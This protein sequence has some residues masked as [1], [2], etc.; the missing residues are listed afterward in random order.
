MEIDPHQYECHVFKDFLTP[1]PHANMPILG[2]RCAL[3]ALHRTLS[4]DHYAQPMDANNQYPQY[5]PLVVALNTICAEFNIPAINEFQLH[6]MQ[7]MPWFNIF[8]KEFIKAHHAQRLIDINNFNVQGSITEDHMVLMTAAFAHVIG[9]DNVSLGIVT[10]VRG[11]PIKAFHYPETDRIPDYTAWIVA[12]FRADEPRFYGIGRQVNQEQQF[13]SEQGEDDEE[14]DEEE[15]DEE[16]A[17]NEDTPVPT[18][19]PRKTAAR[20]LQQQKPLAAGLT[21]NDILQHHKSHLQYNNILK[22]GLVYSNQRIAE[23]CK[24]DLLPKNEQLRHTS[25]VVKRINTGITWIEEQYKIDS[26]AFRTAYDRQ[27]RINGIPTRGKDEIGDDIINANRSKIDAAMD[28]IQV[29]GP[30]PAGS[31]GAASVN[32]A[33]PVLAGPS[34]SHTNIPPGY[35]Q[36]SS[37]PAGTMRPAAGSSHRRGFPMNINTSMMNMNDG[38]NGIQSGSIAMTHGSDDM[39]DEEMEMA[40]D[41]EWNPE[42]LDP[43]RE[44]AKHLFR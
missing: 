39:I 34:C 28:W 23:I 9:L 2:K 41:L 25:A 1:N 10:L 43:E 21:A 27:R 8:A 15:R 40:N 44:L 3:D 35:T 19:T 33:N 30:R 22:V 14:R 29:G 37:T 4:A 13:V 32:V 26:G 16:E 12:D 38:S 5:T 31:N 24:S 7:S 11:Q 6:N 18:T 36:A 42:D 17:D 20:V